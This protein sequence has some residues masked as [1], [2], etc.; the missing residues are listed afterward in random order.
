MQTGR[1]MG[2]A[3]AKLPV[4]GHDQRVR[5]LRYRGGKFLQRAD[6]PRRVQLSCQAETQQRSQNRAGLLLLLQPDMFMQLGD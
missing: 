5:Q 4:I 6:Q 2:G 1:Y 3:G